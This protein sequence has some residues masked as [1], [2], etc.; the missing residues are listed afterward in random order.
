[1]KWK[2]M[3]IQ[4]PTHVFT[5]VSC[6]IAKTQNQLKCHVT[7]N[8][9]SLENHTVAVY[10]MEY[11][12]AT[13]RNKVLIVQQPRWVLRVLCGVKKVTGCILPL[14]QCCQDDMIV[15]MENR[16]VLTGVNGGGKWG[17]VGV[18]RNGKHD[19]SFAPWFWWWL[20]KS[21]LVIKRR[22]I[23]HTQNRYQRADFGVALVT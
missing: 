11:Y 8:S 23:I 13:K 18:T 12:S 7:G 19:R 14:P 15:E 2:L 9:N 20:Q 4:K 22:R 1:M 5:A 16:L 21:A 3:S 6:V 17:G 10:T